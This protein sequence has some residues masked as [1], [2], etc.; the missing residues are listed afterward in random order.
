MRWD[1]VESN[2]G[3][4]PAGWR[5]TGGKG[6]RLAEVVGEALVWR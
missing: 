4:A 6:G 1:S 2:R 3:L 5:V